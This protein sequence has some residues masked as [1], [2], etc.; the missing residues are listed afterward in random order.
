MGDAFSGWR[1]KAGWWK[2]GPS[3]DKG[4]E[5]IFSPVALGIISHRPSDLLPSSLS[6]GSGERKLRRVWFPGSEGKNC[7]R[8]W[9]AGRRG[10]KNEE[11]EKIGQTSPRTKLE[12]SHSSQFPSSKISSF[13]LDCFEVCLLRRGESLVAFS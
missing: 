11:G 12:D 2:R 1:R 13:L 9:R 10:K 5:N 3:R 8:E 7:R 6:A 4:R